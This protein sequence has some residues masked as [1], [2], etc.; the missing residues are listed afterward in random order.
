M[1]KREFQYQGGARI[2]E[3]QNSF[4]GDAV[5][6]PQGSGEKQGFWSSCS[7]RK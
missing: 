2:R 3:L 6:A 4:E 5:T 7:E 1:V